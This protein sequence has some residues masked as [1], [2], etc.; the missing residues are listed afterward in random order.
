M[1][2]SMS[3]RDRILRLQERF[4]G[5]VFTMRGTSSLHIMGRIVRYDTDA[6]S[7]FAWRSDLA[8]STGIHY[9]S[10]ASIHRLLR[11]I[12]NATLRGDLNTDGTVN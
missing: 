9:A 4:G 2:T 10:P 1:N 5:D 11:D 3:P 7:Y 6:Q 12:V 8:Q